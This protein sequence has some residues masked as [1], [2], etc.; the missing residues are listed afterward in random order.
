MIFTQDSQLRQPKFCG[1]YEPWK[2]QAFSHV[3]IS[4]FCLAFRGRLS[5]IPVYTHLPVYHIPMLLQELL[6]Q[7]FQYS[8][9]TLKEKL[10][11]FT[12]KPL[13]SK[14]PRGPSVPRRLPPPASKSARQP[15]KKFSSQDEVK[16]SSPKQPFLA[17]LQGPALEVVPAP[18]H[19]T[20]SQNHISPCSP[21]RSLPKLGAKNTARLLEAHLPRSGDSRVKSPQ[22]CW[23]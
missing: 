9:K 1:L 15:G 21:T 18:T 5:N 7:E 14:P 6:R 23:W 13:D 4:T 20:A 17:R 11:G 10:P 22:R 3:S 2:N 12:K 19:T 8:R 16:H